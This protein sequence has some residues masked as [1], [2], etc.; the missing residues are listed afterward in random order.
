[1]L[2]DLRFGAPILRKPPG[3]AVLA[4]LTLVLEIGATSAV[5]SLMQGVLLTPPPHREPDPLVLVDSTRT[6]GQ[7][8]QSPQG[9]APLEWMGWQKNAKSL[10]AVAAYGWTFNFLVLNDGSESLQEIP[11][12][13]EYF[14]VM[15]LQPL[16]G[17]TFSDSE[18][19]PGTPPVV[20]IGDELCT[21]AKNHHQRYGSI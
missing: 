7:V 9:W 12:M 5:C 15:G 1:M 14:R 18:G 16:M 19:K 11:V 8:M 20:M 13:K 17:R 21:R 4:V 6:D 3:F 10:E 2:N